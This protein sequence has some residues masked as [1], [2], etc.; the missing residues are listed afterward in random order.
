[1]RPARRRPA[2]AAASRTAAAKQ[3]SS[4]RSAYPVFLY[5]I[6]LVFTIIIGYEIFILIRNS[7]NLQLPETPAERIK[8]SEPER[9]WYVD[10]KKPERRWYVNEKK[11]VEVE[12]E[13][14]KS[15]QIQPAKEET[16]IDEKANA[17]R[18][19]LQINF[20]QIPS[21]KMVYS[22]SSKDIC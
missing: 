9:R 17:P 16:I 11:P 2:S 14:S 8:N 21:M 20:V 19:Y 15:D 22:N 7:S 13:T 6:A 3:A 5:I 12:E 18:K 1:M 4:R 10:E